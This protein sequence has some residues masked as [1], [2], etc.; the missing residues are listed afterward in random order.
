MGACLLRANPWATV[1]QLKTAIEQ[2]ASQYSTPDS[3]LGYGIPDFEIAD[4]YLK[5]NHASNLK[6]DIAWSVS[7]NPFSN[8]IFIH[9]VNLGSGDNC[10][11]SISNLQGVCF[12]QSTVKASDTIILKNLANLPEGFLILSIRSGEKEERIKLIKTAR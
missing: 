2:S 3:L 1:K 9:N 6:Q 7:P 4:K 10:L 8:T 11:I 5:V 12:W